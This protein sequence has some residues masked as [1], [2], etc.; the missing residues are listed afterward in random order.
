MCVILAHV[1]PGGF[2]FQ[3]R[4]FDVPLMVLVSGASFSLSRVQKAMYVRYLFS[5]FVRLVIPTWVFLTFFFGAVFLVSLAIN[6]PYPFSAEKVVLSF[7]L[8]N[9]D[10]IGYIWIIRVF[11]LVATIAPYAKKGL[12]SNRPTLLGLSLGLIYIVYEFSAQYFFLGKTTNGF[13]DSIFKEYVFYIIPYGIV[14]VIGMLMQ[15][16][17]L[18]IRFTAALILLLIFFFM[19][20]WLQ[21]TYGKFVPSELYKYPPRIYYLSYAIGLSL[22]LSWLVELLSIDSMVLGHILAGIG[23]R[24][25]WIYLW[26]ISILYFMNWFHFA[27]NFVTKFIIVFFIA[28]SITVIQEYIVKKFI[29]K[30]SDEKKGKLILKIFVG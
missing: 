28:I 7:T 26:H 8:T 12:S 15:Q 5:R 6:H 22:L 25:L 10:G 23:N 14:F 27:F 3:L 4:N 1:G 29:T 20:T 11:F 18:K 16:L 19:V 30:V 17:N 24:T 21:V 13:F 9:W 2:I